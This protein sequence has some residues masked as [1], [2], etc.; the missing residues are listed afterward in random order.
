MDLE[1]K[2]WCIEIDC[3]GKE[4]ALSHVT[5]R[6]IRWY[7]PDYIS[8][9]DDMKVDIEFE[10]EE[11]TLNV[12][13]LASLLKESS[14]EEVQARLNRFRSGGAT[15]FGIRMRKDAIPGERSGRY[16]TLLLTTQSGDIAAYVMLGLG[17]INVPGGNG[18]SRRELRRLNLDEGHGIVPSYVLAQMS[19]SRDWV[20]GLMSVM[21]GLAYSALV[22]AGALVGGDLVMLEC[23]TR[24]AEGLILEGFHV[25]EEDGG[26]VR[27][28]ARF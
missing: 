7:E 20:E 2:P 3:E 23:D 11:H 26:I 19:W 8:V 16:R 9:L 24:Q 14:E 17:R 1:T 21:M 12:I 4:D 15:S 5:G 6:G 13:T 10:G 18:M 22:R 28:L 27:M 25:M